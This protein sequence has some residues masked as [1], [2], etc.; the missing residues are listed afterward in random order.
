MTSLVADVA[1]VAALLCAALDR[2]ANRR[3]SGRDVP[4]GGSASF[5]LAL[6][7]ARNT[8]TTGT[9]I[10]RRAGHRQASSAASASTGS[11]KP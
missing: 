6:Y 7:S 9:A 5:A 1:L 11:G 3:D 8:S 2:A 4:D 10:A